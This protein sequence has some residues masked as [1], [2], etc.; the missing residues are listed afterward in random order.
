MKV[1]Y[2]LNNLD[3][4]ILEKIDNLSEKL[5]KKREFSHYEDFEDIVYGLSIDSI[6]FHIEPIIKKIPS[7]FT[8]GRII[9]KQFYFIVLKVG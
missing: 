8:R 5:N 1:K 9:W 4:T 6:R 3:E 2:F 7:Y